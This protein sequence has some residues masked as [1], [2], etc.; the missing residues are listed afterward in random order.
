[1]FNNT[2]NGIVETAHE[3]QNIELAFMP[4]FKTNMKM[5]NR[6]LIL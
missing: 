4:S 2:G 1:M 5:D 6:A 3:N